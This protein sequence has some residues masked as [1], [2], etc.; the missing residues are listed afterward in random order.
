[1]ATARTPLRSLFRTSQLISSRRPWTCTSC[2]HGW[3]IPRR[4]VA[5]APQKSKKPYYVTTPIFY[6]NAGEYSFQSHFQNKI[7]TVCLIIAPHV[8]HLYTMVIADIMKRWQ[9]LLGN[10]DAQLLTGTDEHGMKVLQ[11]QTVYGFLMVVDIT[12]RSSKPLSKLAWIHK[13][14]AT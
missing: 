1:M 13:H 10:T 9:V 12:L 5:T 4:G 7:L 2:K 14:F 3:T 11:R 8:G 6:V